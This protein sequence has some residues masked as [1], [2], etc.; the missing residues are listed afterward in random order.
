VRLTRG[1]GSLRPPA[2]SPRAR[3]GFGPQSDAVQAFISTSCGGNNRIRPLRPPATTSDSH[4]LTRLV[5]TAW[6][7][8]TSEQNDHLRVSSSAEDRTSSSSRIQTS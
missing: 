5:R 3:Q 1:D 4:V 6:I 2:K 8:A 7:G